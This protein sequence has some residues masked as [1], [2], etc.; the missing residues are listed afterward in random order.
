M[1]APTPLVAE[2]RPGGF[3]NAATASDQWFQ[4]ADSYSLSKPPRTGRRRIR[5]WAGWGRGGPRTWWALQRS[6]WPLR[7]VMRSVCGQHPAEVPL[8]EDQH[9]V[10]LFC[11]GRR[12]SGARTAVISSHTSSTCR[13][14]R[15]RAR[16]NRPLM[17]MSGLCRPAGTVGVRGSAEHGGRPHG[18][19]PDWCTGRGTKGNDERHDD[20]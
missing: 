6:V 8:P 4:A 3:Q 10:V 14:R 5:P 13:V 9:A 1:T 16:R 11:D 19:S 7:V 12:P 18:S 2:P 15:A 20:G 17:P